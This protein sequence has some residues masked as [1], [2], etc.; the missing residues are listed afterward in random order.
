MKD[1][2]AARSE[3]DAVEVPVMFGFNRRFDPS[4]AAARA[5]VEAGRIGEIE[6]LTMTMEIGRASCRE[7]V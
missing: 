6:Q 2:E 7:R 4:F 1:V 5:A 3:L